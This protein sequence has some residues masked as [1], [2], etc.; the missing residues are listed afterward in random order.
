M[1]VDLGYKDI[2]KFRGG[3]QWCKMESK[4]FVSSFNFKL[5]M[6]IQYLLMVKELLSDYQS[7]SF[8]S[9]PINALDFNKTK[10]TF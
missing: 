1:D 9:Y 5:K 10:I 4:D 7:K 2:E 8:N 3:V 6:E